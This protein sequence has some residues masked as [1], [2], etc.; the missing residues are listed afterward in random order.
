MIRKY[1]CHDCAYR[2]GKSKEWWSSQSDKPPGSC[3]ECQHKIVS[4]WLVHLDDTDIKAE[5][6]KDFFD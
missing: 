5:I 3:E 2:L 6:P 4:A 1:L